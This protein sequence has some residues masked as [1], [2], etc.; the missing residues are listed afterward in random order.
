MPK[1]ETVAPTAFTTFYVG[2]IANKDDTKEDVS[3]LPFPV[4]RNMKTVL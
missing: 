4:A 2:G 1:I 3:P